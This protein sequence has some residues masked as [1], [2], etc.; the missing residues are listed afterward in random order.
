VRSQV[1]ILALTATASAAPALRTTDPELVHGEVFDVRGFLQIHRTE[2]GGTAD[3]RDP[4][5]VGKR[6]GFLLFD[7]STTEITGAAVVTR[8]PRALEVERLGVRLTAAAAVKRVIGRTV[9]QTTRYGKGPQRDCGMSDIPSCAPRVMRTTTRSVAVTVDDVSASLAM[10][11]VGGVPRL[12]VCV[13]VEPPTIDRD[14]L[15][16]LG[17]S[18]AG[19]PATFDATT[20]AAL[21]L[22]PAHCL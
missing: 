17:S 14:D 12:V 4:V 9:R 11:V 2:L 7:E 13:L 10:R 20:G 8:G 16:F 18:V 22:R 1:L 3:E 6:L 19:Y 5:V 15:D 21:A